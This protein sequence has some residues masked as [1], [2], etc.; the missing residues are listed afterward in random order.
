[1]DPVMIYS[2][3]FSNSAKFRIN[4][5][6]VKIKIRKIIFYVLKFRKAMQMSVLYRWL[7]PLDV[8]PDP[9]GAY[10]SCS[11]DDSYS[12]IKSV[13]IFTLTW[14]FF[15]NNSPDIHVHICSLAPLPRI[16]LGYIISTSHVDLG[17]V[18]GAA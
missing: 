11:S 17:V 15:T 10:D 13:A 6:C 9:T 14:Q 1:M 7:Q 12:H 5:P 3:K 2:G 8:L 4:I 18:R 16:R